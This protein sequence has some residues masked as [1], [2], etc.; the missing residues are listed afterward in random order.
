MTISEVRKFHNTPEQ[1]FS[2]KKIARCPAFPEM[3]T[4]YMRVRQRML[5]C[6]SM[7]QRSLLTCQPVGKTSQ[8]MSKYVRTVAAD[9]YLVSASVRNCLPLYSMGSID[10]MALITSS[11]AWHGME[12]RFGARHKIRYEGARMTQHHRC[13]ACQSTW[14]QHR[15]AS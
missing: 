10:V 2:K 5:T 9:V 3:S 4:D 13:Q 7:P 12:I 8:S 1:R 6:H 14:H 15:R 11:I